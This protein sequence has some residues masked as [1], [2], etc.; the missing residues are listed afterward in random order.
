MA[1][2]IIASGEPPRAGRYEGANNDQ[3]LDLRV[4]GQN[5]GIISGDVFVADSD[6][7]DYLASFRTVGAA[8]H[9]DE[10]YDIMW[11]SSDGRTAAGGMAVAPDRGGTVIVRLRLDRQLNGL[12][13]GD[14]APITV[15]R[16]SDE[17]RDL[18]VERETERDDAPMDVKRPF[19]GV[20][21]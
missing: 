1:E 7:Q 8:A 14:L 20:S 12:S 6:S 3:F 18:K 15:G 5:Q 2:P 11:F 21:R 10:T 9:D 17:F 19:Q 4:D 13:A 16:R